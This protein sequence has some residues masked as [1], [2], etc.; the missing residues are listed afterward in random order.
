MLLGLSGC[1]NNPTWINVWHGI[2]NPVDYYVVGN[3]KV[4]SKDIG[5]LYEIL[6]ANNHAYPIISNRLPDETKIYTIKGQNST[7]ELA[8]EIF[9]GTFVK[10]TYSGTKKP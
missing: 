2:A 6:S 9:Q 4:P 5:K 10:A 8:V 3:T 7:K 1:G